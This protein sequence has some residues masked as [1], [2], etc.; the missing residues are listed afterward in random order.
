MNDR[1]KMLQPVTQKNI[2][3]TTYTPTTTSQI[4]KAGSILIGDQTISGDADL[5]ASNIKTGVNI[6][7]VTGTYAGNVQDY[8]ATNIRNDANL[9]FSVNGSGCAIIYTSAGYYFPV[10]FNASCVGNGAS[11]PI[12]DGVTAGSGTIRAYS[13]TSTTGIGYA[14]KN[15][16][17]T[18]TNL[19]VTGP[20]I[21]YLDIV[22]NQRV[23]IF[24]HTSF[25][26]NSGNTSTTI[27]GITIAVGIAGYST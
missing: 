27:D 15:L 17:N 20:G 21:V 2:L 16:F 1:R 4:I 23:P 11:A 25:T 19:N 5:T 3:A 14:L 18:R 7:G 10:F 6:F 9:S 22:S 26:T 12:I 24:F 13:Y 8:T